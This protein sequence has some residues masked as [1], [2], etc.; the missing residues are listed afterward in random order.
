MCKKLS[1]NLFKKLTKN[2]LF[3]VIQLSRTISGIFQ[4]NLINSFVYYLFCIQNNVDNTIK[5][6]LLE[7]VKKFSLGKVE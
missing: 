7:N 3:G 2:K 6:F 5:V 4:Q 1:K